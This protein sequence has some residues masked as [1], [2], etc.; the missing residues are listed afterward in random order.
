VLGDVLAACTTLAFIGLYGAPVALPLAGALL[1]VWPIL[2]AAHGAYV[3]EL[4]LA[5]TRKGGRGVARSGTVLALLCWVGSTF[6]GATSSGSA[7]LIAFTGCVTGAG[8]A[9]RLLPKAARRVGTD[10]RSAMRVVLVGHPADVPD[11][12]AELERPGRQRVQVVSVCLSEPGPLDNLPAAAC[13]GVDTAAALAAEHAADAVI[14]LPG[15]LLDPASMRRLQWRLEAAGVEMY[16]G[17][18]LLDVAPFRRSNAIASGLVLVHVSH[19][20]LHGLRRVLKVLVER[21]AAALILLALAPVLLVI[22]LLVRRSSPGPAIFRQERVGLRG[23]TFTMYK[24]RTMSVSAE[25]EL[26]ELTGDNETGGL[27]FKLRQD[28]RV[29]ELGRVLR[30][31]SLDELP[32]LWN[33]VRGDMALVGP[34]PALPSEVAQYDVDPRRRLVVKPGLTGLW[35]VSG[36]SDLTWEDTVRLDNQ[37][38]DNW[39]LGLDLAILVRTA[40]AVLGHHGAY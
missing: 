22:G 23:R 35:Q 1:L 27:L 15:H 30:R 31:Y 19:A 5:E 36:R 39:S 29:T 9:L 20:P 7:T 2:L 24:F 18:G 13:G 37:Y 34:R 11:V 10:P 16:V 8:V 4:P 25:S 6:A 12:L 17:T 38:V 28:P 33:V 3:R 21:L 14:V 26:V 32:Q 40:G